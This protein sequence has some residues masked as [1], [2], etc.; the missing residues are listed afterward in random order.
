MESSELAGDPPSG[1]YL[2]VVAFFTTA[3][4]S[5]C[6]KAGKKAGMM[7]AENLHV[8]YLTCCGFSFCGLHLRKHFPEVLCAK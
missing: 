8:A 3:A 7:E 6:G 4:V 5:P 1:N 2:K